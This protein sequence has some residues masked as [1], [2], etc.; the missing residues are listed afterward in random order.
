MNNFRFKKSN[1][2]VI[3]FII[4]FMMKYIFFLLFFCFSIYS[5]EIY[6]SIE[7]DFPKKS[8]LFQ[9]INEEN[10][11]FLFLVTNSKTVRAIRFDGAFQIKDSLK[12][13]Y[14]PK[15]NL[16]IWGYGYNNEKYYTYWNETKNKNI[17]I[18]MFDFNINKIETKIIS[19]TAI[20][21][22]EIKSITLNN[23]FYIITILKDS[24]ILHIY[25]FDGY[26]LKKNVVN[27]TGITLL[28]DSNKR[29]NLYKMINSS[30]ELETSLSFQTIT[31][32]TPASLVF[33][34]KQRKFYVDGEKVH[35]T[36]DQNIGFSQV[37][38]VDLNNFTFKHYPFSKPIIKNDEYSFEISNSFI[39]KD[40]IFLLRSNK[41]N[42]KIEV[43]DFEKNLISTF[44]A[45]DEN[46]ISFLNTDIIQENQS[47]KNRKILGK[48]KQ[49]LKSI[50]R[51]NGGLT[52]FNY[53][54]NICMTIG[55]VSPIID[56]NNAMMSGLMG[57]LVGSLIYV[58]FS[59]NYNADNINSYNKREAVY[60]HSL[61]NE[62]FEHVT[63]TIGDLPFDKLRNFVLSN[64][65]ELSNVFKF[66]GQLYYGLFNSELKTYNFYKF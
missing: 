62:N 40:K 19:K 33:A 14:P 56:N 35:F 26:D 27:L 63:G 10:D 7:V 43:K 21:G 12:Y 6:K 52:C 58:A 9:V 54:N 60:S 31:Q 66:K 41:K 16:N 23:V 28:D 1:I 11:E 57:G 3:Y 36:F 32:E 39:F 51:L 2:F 48:S 30:F 13:N 44:E 37:I 45:N 34:A 50:D 15:S 18:N 4:K 5:Q 38:T 8:E 64:D 59:T 20:E 25:K 61:L 42:L 22:F 65:G 29:V 46:D 17:H 49:F 47:I 55:G 24:N 53:N